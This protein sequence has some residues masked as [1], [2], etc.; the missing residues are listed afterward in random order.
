MALTVT[1]F[2][3]ATIS[4]YLGYIKGKDTSKKEMINFNLEKL[5]KYAYKQEINP[6]TKDIYNLFT[7]HNGM[8]HFQ[9]FPHYI[10]I[11]LLD[12][13]IWSANGIEH[14][15]IYAKGTNRF[16]FYQ[17]YGK[18]VE[19]VNNSLN[20]GDKTILDKICREVIINEL[21]FGSTILLE[22]EYNFEKQ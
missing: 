1:F 18:H 7:S 5:F 15:T 17:K 10:K 14:R 2:V 22:D 9:M 21:D 8:K 19:A 6:V 12:L 16:I 13:S 11:P 4:F 20:M 3:I